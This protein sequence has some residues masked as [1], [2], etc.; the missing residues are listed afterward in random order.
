MVLARKNKQGPQISD[1]KLALAAGFSKNLHKNSVKDQEKNACVQ[2][3]KIYCMN[4]ER[5]D[6]EAAG[7]V[8]EET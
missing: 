3:Q 6:V 7:A 1:N 5:R 4:G 2:K 8:F